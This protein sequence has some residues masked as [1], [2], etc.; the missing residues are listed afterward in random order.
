MRE[1]VLEFQEGEPELSG[2]EIRALPGAELAHLF[3]IHAEKKLIQPTIIYEF[4]IEIS[5]LANNN[6]EDPKMVDRFELFIA[7]ME[8]G[9]AYTELNNPVEQT[10]RFDAQLN[11]FAT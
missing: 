11:R 5:P 1:A 10:R 8:I 2:E 7:G 9:N 6:A 4:P 3:E